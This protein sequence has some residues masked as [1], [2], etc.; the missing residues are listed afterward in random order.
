MAC[1]ICSGPGPLAA[2]CLDEGLVAGLQW[3]GGKALLRVQTSRGSREQ[4]MLEQMELLPVLLQ[5]QQ[6]FASKAAQVSCLIFR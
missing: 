2:A 1:G 6:L 3:Y 5:S 4:E